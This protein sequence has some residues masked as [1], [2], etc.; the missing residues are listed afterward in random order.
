[1]GKRQS[2]SFASSD[3]M[4]AYRAE[5][6]RRPDG[7]ALSDADGDWLVIGTLFGH[8][9]Y[10]A[11][12]AA[13]AALLDQARV[14]LRATLGDGRWSVGDPLDPAPPPDDAELG[15]RV[16]ALCA[17]V[18]DH[19]A[20]TLADAILSAYLASGDELSSLERGRAD[21]LRARFAWKRGDLDAAV[22]LYAAVR[23][24]GRALRSAELKA[25]AEIGDAVL[26]RMRGNLPESRAAATRAIRHAGERGMERLAALAHHAMMVAVAKAGDTDAAL[27]HAWRAFEGVR[28]DASAEGVHLADVAHLFHMSGR[29]DLAAPA[30][31]VALRLPLPLR[32]LLPALG[33]AALT[34]ASRGDRRQVLAFA[35]QA[36]SAG[37]SAAQSFAAA[38]SWLDVA[39]ACLVVG[40]RETAETLRALAQSIATRH[41]YH[42]LEFRAE[43][44]ATPERRAAPA[45]VSLSPESEE[46]GQ[47]VR[48]LAAAIP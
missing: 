39:Q 32:S 45:P 26:A 8:A 15:P 14:Q 23:R 33:G 48:A 43:Q 21:A 5:L 3:V 25:R 31:A 27:H 16:R 44:L 7:D 46:I 29:D 12:A 42:E 17:L 18:E 22:A 11:D 20:A 41:G 28:G 34:A 1:M 19:D 37:E 6:A 47:V 30:F 2:V 24:R 4:S 35:E 10:A 9:G 36:R 13:R 40:E 38:D